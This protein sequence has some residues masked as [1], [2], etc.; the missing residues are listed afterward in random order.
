MKLL[1]IAQRWGGGP[2]PKAVVEGLA[3]TPPPSKLRSMVTASWEP[4][5]KNYGP[6]QAFDDGSRAAALWLER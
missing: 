5:V 2:L 3:L 1:L 6:N 4:Y